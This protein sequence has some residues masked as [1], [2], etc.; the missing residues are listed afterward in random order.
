MHTQPDI[1][2]PRGTKSYTAIIEQDGTT[3]PPVATVLHNNIGNIVWTRGSTGF[4]IGTLTGAFPV[5]KT[6][7][8]VQQDGDFSSGLFATASA[9]NNANTINL[10]NYHGDLNA[11]DGMVC[12]LKIIVY[13]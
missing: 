13:V 10:Y 9:L 6:T 3:A 11:A 5:R 12:Y 1:H 8:F 7:V 4:Y 2:M